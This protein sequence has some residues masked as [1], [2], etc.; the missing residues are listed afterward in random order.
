[1]K[2]FDRELAKE[3]RRATKSVVE[4][5]WKEALAGNVRTRLE[6]RVLADTGRAQVSDQN[7]TLRS[8]AVG[9]SIGGRVKPVDL[10]GGVEFGADQEKQ[11]TYNA[12]GGQVTRHT[13]RQFS[14]RNRKGYVVYP[15]VAKVIPRIAALW[16]QTVVRT[17][18]EA[19]ERR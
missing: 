18:Y 5:V 3:I 16:V 14:P 10:I 6:A 11:T 4:P 12:R 8:A 1:M 19:L 9:R 15:A 17:T 13:Q 2:S 7:V